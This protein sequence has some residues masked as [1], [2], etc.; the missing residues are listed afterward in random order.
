MDVFLAAVAL[1]MVVLLITSLH[2]NAAISLLLGA[3]FLGLTT[4]SGLGGTSALI[5]EGFGEIMSRVGLL[6]GFGVLIGALLFA[7][8]ALQR[9]SELLVRVLGTGRLPY[10]LAAT[11]SAV[12]PSIY[13]DV[14]LVLAAPLARSAAPKLGPHGLGVMAG[15][16]TAGILCGYAF[17]IPG[18]VTVTTAGLVGAPLASMLLYGL[19]VGP[20]TAVVTV[21]I[22][23]RLLRLGFWK[24]DKDEAPS[25]ALVEEESAPSPPDNDERTAPLGLALLPIAIPLIMIAVATIATTWGV[26]SAVLDALGNPAVALFVGLVGA[27]LLARA[28]LGRPTTDRALSKGFDTLGQIL[29]ITGVGG[30]FGAVIAHTNLADVLTSLFDAE[31]GGSVITVILL[32]WLI[33]AVLHLAVGSITVAAVTSATALASVIGQLDV[34]PVAVALAISAGAIFAVTV[35]S[36]FFWMFQTLLGVSTRGALKALTVLSAISSV[37]ALPM[38]LLLALI[39]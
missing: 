17:V 2:V 26:E 33:A 3:T 11:L 12:F 27:Y 9:F 4:G 6:I 36:N 15:T 25:H 22:W 30:S 24:P 10:T 35:H 5:V 14:Q 21:F 28:Y 29:L 20:V 34:A 18:L 32:A 39:P 16:L 7:L 8:G 19:I 1:V 38:V 13:G 37:V 23:H 31:S